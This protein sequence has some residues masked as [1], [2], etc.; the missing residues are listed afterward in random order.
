MRARQMGTAGLAGWRETVADKA[1]PAVA[2][3]T[4]IDEDAIRAAIGAAFF[5]LSVV[6]VIGTIKRALDA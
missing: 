6:Y 5:A 4:P 3:R 1:A 2:A